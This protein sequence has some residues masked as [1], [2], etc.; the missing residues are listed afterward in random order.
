MS[1]EIILKAM[2]SLP[3]YDGDRSDSVESRV[4]LYQPIAEAISNV[5]KTPEETAAL[6]SM[7]ENETHFARYV[8]EDRCSDGPRGQRCDHG[9]ARGPWQVH[10]WCRGGLEQQAHC[11]LQLLNSGYSRC[12]EGWYG[13]F[14][15]TRGTK[16]CSWPP[17][18]KRVHT[19]RIVLEE[20]Q[21]GN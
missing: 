18:F 14:T 11:A 10:S 3:V 17:A 5:A 2:L 20:F 7:A 12:G 1:P 19:M 9:H 4:E 13:A 16:S 15:G 6:L 8:L 21:H